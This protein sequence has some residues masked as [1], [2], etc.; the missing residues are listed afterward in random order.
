MSRAATLIRAA[1]TSTGLTQSDLARR[2]GTTQSAI[3]RLERPGSNPTLETLA[4]ALAAAEHDLRLDAEPAPAPVDLGQ[5]AA[6]LR[7]TPTQRLATFAASYRS[8]RRLVQ[9]AAPGR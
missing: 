4:D 5:I 9:S 8:V 1:R 3:A 7:M 2:L 6:H